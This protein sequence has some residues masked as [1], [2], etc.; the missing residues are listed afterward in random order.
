MSKKEIWMQRALD[1]ALLGQGQV[2][3]NPLVGCVI[4]KDNRVIGEGWHQ[5]YGGPHAEV[6]AVNSVSNT[7]DLENSEVYVTLE[8]C[9]H[10][11]KTPPCA[12]LLIT[13]KVGK[14]YICNVDPNPLVAGKG[15][16]KLKNAGIDVQS[17]ILREKGTIINQKFFTFHKVKRPFITLKFACS[18]DGYI[19]KKNGDAVQFSNSV[20][21]QLVHKL[22]AE[23]QAILIGVNTANNDN[24]SLST[25]DWPGKNPLRIILDPNNK[26]KPD[27]TLL[28][29]ENPTWIFNKTLQKESFGKFWWK[30]SAENSIEF[31]QEVL[32]FCTE[33]NIQS[34]LVEGGSQTLQNFIESN[35][36]DELIQ[37]TNNE[38]ELQEGIKAP[39]INLRFQTNKTFGTN[40]TWQIWNR[41]KESENLS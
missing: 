5:R 40:N 19:A 41:L 26:L 37:I 8:P 34:I 13:Y 35:L 27:L 29:D 10:F 6:N 38:I 11:G 9:S 18:A 14:V 33:K 21:Q 25:R 31:L 39:Q 2:A 15:I 1:L 28:K 24:P 23:H 16:E 7:D 32:N 4:V 3:P 30:I 36:F 22:R 12:D 20:S 17:G